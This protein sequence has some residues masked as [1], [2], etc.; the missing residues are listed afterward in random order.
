MFRN[1]CGK[2]T[3]ARSSDQP[4]EMKWDRMPEGMSGWREALSTT[5]SDTHS[6]WASA[7]AD[8]NCTPEASGMVAMMESWGMSGSPSKYIWVI[9]L[10]AKPVP[11]TEKWMW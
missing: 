7:I 5:M 2:V 9:S 1:T 8:A 10:C 4:D 3:M 11:N 6:L